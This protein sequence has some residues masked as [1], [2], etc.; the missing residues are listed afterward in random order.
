MHLENLELNT[1]ILEKLVY[2]KC[3]HLVPEEKHGLFNKWGWHDRVSMW[4]NI[5]N[6]VLYK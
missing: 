6:I 3:D 2:D 1:G 5:N 4:N